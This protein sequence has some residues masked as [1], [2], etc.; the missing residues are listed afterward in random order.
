[1]ILRLVSR[2]CL[3][4]NTSL[5]NSPV[6]SDPAT[7]GF[8]SF[9]STGVTRPFPH[10]VLGVIHSLPDCLVCLLSSTAFLCSGFLTVCLDLD[11]M[12]ASCWLSWTDF[13]VFGSYMIPSKTEFPYICLFLRRAF[14]FRI[15]K[16]SSWLKSRVISTANHTWKLFNSL[17][18]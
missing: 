16:R 1:M 5:T 15:Q 12:F 13:L 17:V 3:M 4:W 2:W 11:A 18:K 10:L 8:I 14:G 7:A 6:A 9:P